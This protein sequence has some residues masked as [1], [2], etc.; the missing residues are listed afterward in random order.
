[1]E[2]QLESAAGF[3]CARPHSLTAEEILERLLELNLERSDGP[4]E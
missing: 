3:T 1:M 2:Q 4:T